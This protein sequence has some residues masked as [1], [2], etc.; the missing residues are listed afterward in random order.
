MARC[1]YKLPEEFLLKCS[2]LADKT[3]VIME[4]VL[5]DGGTVVLGKVKSN[6]QSVIG[7]NTKYPSKSTGKLAAALGMTTVKVDR[8]GNHNLKIGFSE[9]RRCARSSRGSGINALIA[10]VLEHGKHNQPPRPF[11]KTAKSASK[12]SCIEAMKARLERE[13]NNL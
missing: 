9:P 13:I 10:N 7:K 12:N 3:D 2:R 8:R 4:N 5:Q 1:A 6:L 11:L